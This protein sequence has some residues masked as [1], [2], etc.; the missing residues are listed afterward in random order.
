MNRTET[1]IVSDL[2]ET[3]KAAKDRDTVLADSVILTIANKIEGDD[4][5]ADLA[6]IDKMEEAEV[7]QAKASDI[8][9]AGEVEK[10]AHAF[11]AKG[12]ADDDLMEELD[13]CIVADRKRKR[14][15]VN[16]LILLEKVYNKEELD[17]CPIVGSGPKRNEGSNAPVDLFTVPGQA[18]KGSFYRVL[19][20]SWGPGKEAKDRYDAILGKVG[21]YATM[22]DRT[23][24]GR[25]DDAKG[26]FELV[27]KLTR[28]AFRVHQMMQA[29]NELE[30]CVAS[31]DYEEIG[32]EKQLTNS[33]KPIVIE[34]KGKP[35]NYQR[36]SVGEFLKCDPAEAGKQAVLK[37]GKPSD[38]YNALIATM[39][40]EPTPAGGKTSEDKTPP[41]AI[42]NLGKYEEYLIEL[43]MA[44]ENEVIDISLTKRIAVAL[45]EKDEHFIK[46]L[47]DLAH[48]LDGKMNLAQS[49][50][51]RIINNE[52]VAAAA[53]LEA[54][55]SSQKK[56]A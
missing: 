23:L 38:Y 25:L 21:D 10:A 28:D 46:T 14:G 45:K 27:I 44:S 15:A 34:E 50:Y 53:K 4:D 12:N 51:D 3:F 29:V 20:L 41:K 40:K 7:E 5:A 9:I 43:A 54:E 36:K 31:Y 6:R 49:F 17:A 33:K 22:D 24:K 26:D 8:S 39:G 30:G 19:A 56:S 52:A 1:K 2:R 48:Y 47:G 55:M 18:A 32:D 16:F 11:A 42:T 35:R 13:A 37:G